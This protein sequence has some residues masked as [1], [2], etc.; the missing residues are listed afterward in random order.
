[1]NRY[2]T[3]KTLG[4]GTYGSV[5]LAK[6]NDDGALVAIKKMKKKFYSWDE[7][8]NLRE[9]KSLK[10]MNHVNIV[11]LREVVREHDNLFFVFEYM[12]GNG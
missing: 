6:N 12:K 5:Y 2:Q 7:A 11:K 4:D 9:V 3:I 1:M 8:I 10:K